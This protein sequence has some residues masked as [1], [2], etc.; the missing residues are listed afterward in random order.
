MSESFV[1]SSIR[2]FSAAVTDVIM[3]LELAM[4]GY[5]RMV[6]A[7]TLAGPFFCKLSFHRKSIV[8]RKDY[9]FRHYDLHGRSHVFPT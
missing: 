2:S 9:H 5:D 1:A 7:A 3:N 6:F 4:Q 8:N